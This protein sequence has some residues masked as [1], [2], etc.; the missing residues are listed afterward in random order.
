MATIPQAIAVAVQHHQAGRLAEAEQIYRQ[1]LSTDPNN[2]DALHLLGVIAQQ[3]G[4]PD[5][6]VDLIRR[7]VT[8]MPQMAEAHNNLGVSL[9]DQGKL[10]EAVESCQRALQIKPDYAEA[11]NNLGVSLK[12]L[13]KLDEAVASYQRALQIKPDYAEAHSNL[14]NALKKQGKLDEAV[15]KA[16]IPQAFAAAVQHHQAGR[17]AE[18]ERIYR[19][20]L[21]IN[22]SN[23]NA[24][25]LLGVVAQQCSKAEVAVDLIRQDVTLRPQMGE[26]HNNLG[27]RLRD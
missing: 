24:L 4:K 10:D 7:A 15:G 19:Q 11:H 27:V 20:I 1:V 3:R 22:P 21:G 13:G 6:A 5:M 17:L 2:A 23:V 16:T 26:A 12:E 18:A 9:R 14:G 25:H 8:L